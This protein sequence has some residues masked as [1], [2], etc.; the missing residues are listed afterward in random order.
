VVGK[1]FPGIKYFAKAM[2]VLSIVSERPNIE[3][4][5]IWLLL[6]RN[7]LSREGPYSC[8]YC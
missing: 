3:M 4:V 5:E 7:F 6:V 1:A 8:L 2:R